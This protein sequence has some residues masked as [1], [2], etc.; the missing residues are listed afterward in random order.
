MNAYVVQVLAAAAG[1]RTRFRGTAETGPVPDEKRDELRELARDHRGF[2]RTVKERHRH[3]GARQSWV[4]HM[5]KTLEFTKIM[6]L[7]RDFD[8]ECPW[9]YVEWDELNGPEWPEGRE[10]AD[11]LDAA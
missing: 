4:E 1:H 3:I 6:S 10:P 5:R 8:A 11:H 2:P 7:V 9:F